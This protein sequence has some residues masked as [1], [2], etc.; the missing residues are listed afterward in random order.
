VHLR[1]FG[2]DKEVEWMEKNRP[3]K[4][5]PTRAFD[6]LKSVRQPKALTARSE[7]LAASARS[8]L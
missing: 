4:T 7:S 5:E 1:E 6:H 3:D 2:Y 8:S